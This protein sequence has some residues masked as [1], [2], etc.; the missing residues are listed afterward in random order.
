MRASQARDP[1]SNPGG[2]TNILSTYVA[3]QLNRV[4][5]MEEMERIMK[6]IELLSQGVETRRL[7]VVAI[8]RNGKVES[9]RVTIPLDWAEEL[10]IGPG[11]EVLAIKDPQSRS[12]TYVKTSK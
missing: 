2:G 6:L 4:V 3:I 1:G 9:L 5:K 10:G 8:K 7:K 11:D 12:I